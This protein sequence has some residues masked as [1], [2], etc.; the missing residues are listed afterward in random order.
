MLWVDSVVLAFDLREIK[1]SYEAVFCE[2]C[3]ELVPS[4]CAWALG[5]VSVHAVRLYHN[6]GSEVAVGSYFANEG[7]VF[8]FLSRPGL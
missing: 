8:A 2:V 6:Y 5:Q 3:F 4:D 1:G 7:P